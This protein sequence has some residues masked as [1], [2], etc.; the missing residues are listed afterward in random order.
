MLKVHR[1]VLQSKIDWFDPELRGELV[2]SGEI[3]R[4]DKT[5][6]IL[7]TEEE[8]KEISE[9][10][11]MY[12]LSSDEDLQILKMKAAQYGRDLDPVPIDGDCLLHAFR[13]QCYLN[14]R[15]SIMGNREMIAYYMAKLP[16][17]FIL[18]ANPYL[19]EPS[20]ESY[21]RN[22]WHG[23][24]YGDEL[25]TS[26]WGHIWNL[27]PTII[28]PCHADLKCFHAEETFPDIVI[29]HN[30][31][32]EPEGHYFA[33]SKCFTVYLPVLRC[34]QRFSALILITTLKHII[35]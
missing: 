11:R 3:D 6:K 13:K 7:Y 23:Y 14:H 30:G 10:A 5:K 4:D 28:S 12:Y 20:Y 33:T 29:C 8:K 21:V 17:Q 22:F 24:S 35:F 25:V 32:P 9:E 34:L 1:D 2:Q 19:T 16:E 26:A 27:R 15:W 31:R 18:Y